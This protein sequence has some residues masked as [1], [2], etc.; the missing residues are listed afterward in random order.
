MK[1]MVL[2]QDSRRP[3]LVSLMLKLRMVMYY[4]LL[5]Y[6]GFDEVLLYYSS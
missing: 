4:C 6:V 1:N 2:R 3:T 5:K